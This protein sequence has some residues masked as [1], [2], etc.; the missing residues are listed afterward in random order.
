MG[1]KSIVETLVETWHTIE[2]PMV[3]FTDP[4]EDKA[5]IA[6]YKAAIELLIG[7]YGTAD[8]IRDFKNSS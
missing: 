5:E 2:A 6:K 8:E 7:W 3:F 4:E 1:M